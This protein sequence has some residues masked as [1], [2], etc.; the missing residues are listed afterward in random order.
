[1]GPPVGYIRTKIHSRSILVKAL[2][3]SGNLCAD[4]ISD[5]L[6]NKLKLKIIP[7]QK[8]VGTAASSGAIKII[9]RI[10]RVKIFLENIKQA[11]I[12]KPYVVKDLSHHINLGQTCLRRNKAKLNFSQDGGVLEI[13]GEVTKLKNRSVPITTTTADARIQGVLSILKDQGGNPRPDPDADML[14]LRIHAM[15]PEGPTKK[16]PIHFDNNRVNLY[17]KQKVKI[18][19]QCS[20]IITLTSPGKNHHSGDDNDVFLIPK[21]NCQFTNKNQ[22]LVHPG[23]YRRKGQDT[24]VLITNFG[25]KDVTLPAQCN[26]GHKL[27]AEAVTHVN[28]L[29]RVK[30]T[31][32]SES[33]TNR[34]RKF[35][36]ELFSFF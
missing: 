32:M 26:V 18:K 34:W 13:R 22:L 15:E 33:E 20:S 6:A 31:E 29:S 36:I 4:L 24:E 30:L 28:E 7:T 35:I 9:G 21:T 11:I 5:T 16:R 1:M 25:D 19:A 8:E 10:P 12:I 2:V 14:D 17:N 27:E 3:D 23:C